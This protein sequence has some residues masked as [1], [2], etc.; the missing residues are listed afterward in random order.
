MISVWDRKPVP[1]GLV[2]ATRVF[3]PSQSVEKRRQAPRTMSHSSGFLCW[4]EPVPV[5]QPTAITGGLSGVTRLDRPAGGSRQARNNFAVDTS[6]FS[7]IERQT[8]HCHRVG[9]VGAGFRQLIRHCGRSS[10]N[11]PRDP[12]SNFRLTSPHATPRLRVNAIF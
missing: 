11:D 4:S 2:A 9:G 7:V 12:K 3:W 10:P 6:A 5:F 1:I 8:S